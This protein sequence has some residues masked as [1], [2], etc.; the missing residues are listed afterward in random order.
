MRTTN[1]TLKWGKEL[2]VMVIKMKVTNVTKFEYFC[3]GVSLVTS[4]LYTS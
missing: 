4:P 3:F 1:C 2:T